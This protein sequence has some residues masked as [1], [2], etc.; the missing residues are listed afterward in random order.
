MRRLHRQDRSIA[1][2]LLALFDEALRR[3]QGLGCRPRRGLCRRLLSHFR[4]RKLVFTAELPIAVALH[5]GCMQPGTA[6]GALVAS[7]RLTLGVSPM[8]CRAHRRTEALPPVAVATQPDL[9]PA[10]ATQQQS[11]G[12][13]G[14]HRSAEVSRFLDDDVDTG[15]TRTRWRSFS[16]ALASKARAATRALR[17]LGPAIA[18]RRARA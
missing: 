4:C 17:I 2:G 6:Q 5:S 8:R 13:G 14:V 1:S 15:D 3:R 9:L 7:R 10:M 12:L 18:T 16:A 11:K